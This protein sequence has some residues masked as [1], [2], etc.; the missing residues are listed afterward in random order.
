MGW[1]ANL[2]L[3]M[4]TR[5]IILNLISFQKDTEFNESERL[6]PRKEK[7]S[8]ISKLWQENIEKNMNSPLWGTPYWDSVLPKI[9]VKPWTFGC[10]I[11]GLLSCATYA[12]YR[13]LDIKWNHP[14]Y[15]ER[16]SLPP[17]NKIFL[18]LSYALTLRHWGDVLSNICNYCSVWHFMNTHKFSI[19]MRKFPWKNNFM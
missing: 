18:G 11:H 1:V 12:Y 5:I 13:H 4:N 2:V 14:V 17:K 8:R 9:M 19:S 7:L 16:N 3:I 6:S 15:S 10:D